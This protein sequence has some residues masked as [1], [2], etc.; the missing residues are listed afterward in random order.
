MESSETKQESQT[1]VP[2]VLL[3]I[4]NRNGLGEDDIR[5]AVSIIADTQFGAPGVEVLWVSILGKLP[6]R[7][8]ALIT[9]SDDD[10]AKEIAGQTIALRYAEQDCTF[11]ISEAF[12]T[13]AK[14]ENDE[15]PHTIFV[16]NIP[17]NCEQ[18]ELAVELSD[19]FAAVAKPTKVIFPRNWIES[20]TVLLT[21]DNVECAKMVMK[22]GIICTFKEKLMKCSY[23]RKRGTRQG[24]PAHKPAGRGSKPKVKQQKPRRDYFME[25]ARK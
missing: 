2:K 19:F 10:V 12:G 14:E 16:S 20:R 1:N 21:F 23:A 11:E 9:L 24:P 18:E 4:L 6:D 7:P 5:S 3:F 8:H 17:V 15:D 13:D 22:V 25:A